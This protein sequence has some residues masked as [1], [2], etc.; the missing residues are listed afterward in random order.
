MLSQLQRG[1]PVKNDPAKALDVAL[2]GALPGSLRRLEDSLRE[3][4]EHREQIA[5]RMREAQAAKAADPSRDVST[6][7]H[8]EQIIAIDHDLKAIDAQIG[9][10]IKQL[11]T[12]RDAAAADY[13]ASLAQQLNAAAPDLAASLDRAIA[14]VEA[15]RPLYVAAVRHAQRHG[16]ALPRFLEGF[17][18]TLPAVQTLKEFA[19]RLKG[20]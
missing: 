15:S 5:A 3:L 19:A 20:R 8:D 14:A 10:K 13:F 2:D 17:R 18:A 9:E 6:R 16:F 7:G 12:A 4:R 1:V 11:T